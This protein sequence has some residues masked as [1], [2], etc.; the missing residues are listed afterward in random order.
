VTTPGS[1]NLQEATT[2]LLNGVAQ[3][4]PNLRLAG[5]QQALRISQRTAIGTPLVNPSPLGG[6]ERI[7]LYTTFLANGAL[8]YYLTVVPEGEAATFQDA[9]RHIGDSIRLTDAR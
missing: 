5:E 1:R 4:N 7:A 3:S 6:R 2:A 9:F 8:F